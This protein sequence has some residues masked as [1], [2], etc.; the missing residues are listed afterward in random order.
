VRT[1]GISLLVAKATVYDAAGNVIGTT[2]ASD[3]F[4]GDLAIPSLA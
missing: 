3:P 1:S 2:A 4:S